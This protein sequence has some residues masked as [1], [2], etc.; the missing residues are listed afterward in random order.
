M[1]HNMVS[2]MIALLLVMVPT[3]CGG[4]QPS[5]TQQS[6]PA[7]PEEELAENEK[8]VREAGDSVTIG[9]QPGALLEDASPETS[10]IMLY[11]YDGETVSVRSLYDV[12]QEKAL[13]EKLNALP[14]TET[15]PSALADWKVPCYGFWI[16][17]KDGCG[18]SA[19][20]SDGL[21]LDQDG[22]VWQVEAD[23]QAY[24]EELEGERQED[25]LTVLYYPNSEYLSRYDTRFLAEAED[26]Y[27]AME[28]PLDVTAELLSVEDGAATV[29]IDNHSGGEYQYGEYFSLQQELDGVWYEMVPKDNMAFHDIAYCLP[30]MGQ[31]TI[32]CDLTAYYGE[33]EPGSYRL[34]KEE[35]AMAFSVQTDGSVVIGS[36]ASNQT[37]TL[38][39]SLDGYQ[40]AGEEE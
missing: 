20:W 35:M 12:E 15:D 27:A 37:D 3:A 30:D 13:L 4:N 22:K 33:L 8:A 24:W 29:L 2:L 32:T 34:I 10:S 17:D 19:A 25:G 16:C 28:M 6:V 31:A 23:F 38:T 21:W 5:D 26:P 7:D 1:K 14:A 11:Y 18:L 40:I 39:A 36:S 9:A